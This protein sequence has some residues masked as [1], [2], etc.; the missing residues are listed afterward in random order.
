MMKKGLNVFTLLILIAVLF[1]SACSGKT[2]QSASERPK[3]PLRIVASGENNTAPWRED[4]AKLWA[5]RNP[6]RTYEFSTFPSDEIGQKVSVMLSGGDDVDIIYNSFNGLYVQGVNNDNYMDLTPLYERDNIPFSKF[7]GIVD[8]FL[9]NGKIYGMPSNMNVWQIYYNKDMFDKRGVP[10]PPADGNWTWEDYREMV[11]KLTYKDDNNNQVYGGWFMSWEACVQNI[12]VQSGKHTMVEKDYSFLKYPYELVLG[13]QKEGTIMPYPIIQANNLRYNSAFLNQTTATVYQG[14]WMATSLMLTDKESPIPF[15]W[16]IAMAP[17]PPD[18]KYGQ[19]V[20]TA[21]IASI[22]VNAANPDDA[23]EYLKILNSADGSR[24]LAESGNIPAINDEQ[25]TVVALE[26]LG[27]DPDETKQAF[28]FNDFY[29]ELAVHELLGPIDRVT[30]EVHTLIMT[31]SCTIDEGI[32]QLN[33]RIKQI[34][35]EYEAGN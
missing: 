22:N 14:N 18:A 27:L 12:G 10:Y 2:G 5:E 6:G 25:Y 35:D 11:R 24:F 32:K 31:E 19:V 34:W 7:N 20:G 30:Q 3:K 29:F 8:R 1:I 13:M 16:G 23:W 28:W 17:Y 33:E 21:F 26:K 9:V 4:I 15:R